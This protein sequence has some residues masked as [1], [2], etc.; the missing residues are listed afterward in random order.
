[1]DAGEVHLETTRT[2]TE[3]IQS[4]IAQKGKEHKRA[5]RSDDICSLVKV[6]GIVLGFLLFDCRA[7]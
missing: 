6:V 7:S 3:L 2:N 5:L 4:G 1:M